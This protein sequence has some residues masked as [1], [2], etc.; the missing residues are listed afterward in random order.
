MKVTAPIK[1]QIKG[2]V[3]LQHRLEKGE[4]ARRVP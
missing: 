2:V 1:I 3:A 4:A